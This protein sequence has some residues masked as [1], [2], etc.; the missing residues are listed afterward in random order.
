MQPTHEKLV[1][2]QD[3]LQMLIVCTKL[4]EGV[5][6][7]SLLRSNICSCRFFNIYQVLAELP[8]QREGNRDLER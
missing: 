1:S 4:K 3:P 7:Q 2:Y 8:F 6:S 5:R